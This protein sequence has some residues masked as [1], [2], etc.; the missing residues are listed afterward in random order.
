MPPNTDASA[1]SI[2]AADGAPLRFS[3][4]LL[5]FLA[6]RPRQPAFHLSDWLQSLDDETLGHLRQLTE[7]IL[8]QPEL[9]G[10]AL[11]D[12]MMLVIQLLA[13]ERQTLE[14]KFGQS[15]M[16]EYIQLLNLLT[17]L[18]RLR[19][20]GLLSYASFMSIELDAAN[21]LTVDKKA[22]D[23]EDAIRQQFMRSLH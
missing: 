20:Q 6:D 7:Q 23:L 12:V 9:V 8:Q 5:R 10:A 13:A 4:N 16:G 17:T 18:E 1:I 22:F 2:A 15:Q 11:E 21:A 3:S 14:I 19:R